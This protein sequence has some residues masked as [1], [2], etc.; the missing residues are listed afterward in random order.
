EEVV[1]RL[2]LAV[3]DDRQLTPKLHPEGLIKSP[4]PLGVGDPHHRME[5]PRQ[6]EN[7]TRAGISASAAWRSRDVVVCWKGDKGAPPS[8]VLLERERRLGHTRGMLTLFGA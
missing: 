2:E 7:P 4:T 1:R 3:A 6:A 8:A 5:E